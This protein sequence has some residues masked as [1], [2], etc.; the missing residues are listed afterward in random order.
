MEP[1]TA[2][3]RMDAA[4]HEFNL[5]K[6][7]KAAFLLRNIAH[8]LRLGVIQLLSHD[9]RY[10]VSDICE[11]LGAEQSLMSH[12]LSNMRMAGLLSATREGKNVY[13][14]LKE[15]DVLEILACIENCNCNY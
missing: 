7:E 2:A 13:Y 15:R 14:A 3:P 9:E 5:K 4:T 10:S 12:H 1:L 8:P 6:L 11:R